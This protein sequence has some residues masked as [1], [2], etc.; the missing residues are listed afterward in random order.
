MQADVGKLKDVAE[1]LFCVAYG[2]NGFEK[3]QHE[4][5][6]PFWMTY[7]NCSFRA[8]AALLYGCTYNVVL[9]KWRAC[10]KNYDGKNLKLD[11]ISLDNLPICSKFDAHS[12]LQYKTTLDQRARGSD[13]NKAMRCVLLRMKFSFQTHVDL[14]N[15]QS[16]P[17]TVFQL[18]SIFM[19]LNFHQRVALAINIASCL[20][21]IL[22]CG[23]FKG[24]GR[25]IM[26]NNRRHKPIFGQPILVPGTTTSPC[27]SF[28]G[29]SNTRSIYSSITVADYVY[30]RLEH[31]S[32]SS[33]NMHVLEPFLHAARNLFQKKFSSAD[34]TRLVAHNLT[35]PNIFVAFEG[36]FFFCF[37]KNEKSAHR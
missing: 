29:I 24:C 26:S 9:G 37:V 14:K 23:N 27:A 28:V 2:L 18:S 31:L 4:I 33:M 30:Y 7:Y 8:I 11:G 22:T 36:T 12:Q 35:P 17:S 1:T 34:K 13:N 19:S 15:Q 20:H 16:F 21:Q 5:A 6:I 25:F 10:V 32:A 3:I